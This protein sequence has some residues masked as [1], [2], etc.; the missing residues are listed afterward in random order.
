MWDECNLWH[1]PA[2]I[3]VQA[4]IQGN[5]P[6]CSHLR[7]HCSVS[8]KSPM[9][10][11]GICRNTIISYAI[12]CCSSY[13]RV[14][15]KFIRQTNSEM[16]EFIVGSSNSENMQINKKTNMSH[17]TNMNNYWRRV[18]HRTSQFVCMQT[19]SRAIPE[20]EMVILQVFITVIVFIDWTNLWTAVVL[21]PPL[22]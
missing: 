14:K 18:C 17:C 5:L 16:L 2:T 10:S 1:P 15:C 12:A 8:P 21:P 9:A 22:C 3:S 19:W 6:D 11:T 7:R 13:P 4:A 20:P